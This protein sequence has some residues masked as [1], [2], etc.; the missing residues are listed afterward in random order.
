MAKTFNRTTF[1]VVI[2]TRYSTDLQ[3][4]DSCEDQENRV[5]SHLSKLG[6]PLAHVKVINDHAV[7]GTRNDREG[8][9]E[10]QK[11]IQIGDVAVVAVDE[12]SRLTRGF[13]LRQMV[14]DVVAFQGQF[15]SV[16][17]NMRATPEN[18]AWKLITTFSEMMN[19]QASD[20][21]GFR[22]TRG[23][24]G[25]FERDLS[26]G[27]HPYGFGTSYVDD[28]YLAQLAKH[29]KPPKEIYIDERQSPIVI[30]IFTLYSAGNS[31]NRIAKLL[32]DDHVPFGENPLKCNW[33]HQRIGSIL[34]NEKY[35]GKWIWGKTKTS[36]FSSGKKAQY[37]TDPADWTE[38]DRQHLRIVN[39][40]L[41][42][43]VQRRLDDLQQRLGQKPEQGRRGPIRHHLSGI[44]SHFL[45]GVLQCQCGKRM[46]IGGHHGKQYF[47]CPD[48]LMKNQCDRKTYVPAELAKQK[49]LKFIIGEL[50]Q[51]V[52]WVNQ[53][54]GSM[55]LSIREQQEDVPALI[56]CA[57]KE[58]AG[59]RFKIQ[60]LVSALEEG[61]SSK[62]I[63]EKLAL[64]ESELAAIEAQIREF[65]QSQSAVKK[66]PTV[67][68]FES[69]LED[70]AQLIEQ[71]GEKAILVFQK[72]IPKIVAVE[73]VAPWKERGFA[74]LTFEFDPVKIASGLLNTREGI[75]EEAIS[76]VEAH[77]DLRR[78]ISIDLGQPT[79]FEL[80][81]EEVHR[82]HLAGESLNRLAGRFAV[83]PSQLW[84]NYQK[85]VAYL[86]RSDSCQDSPTENQLSNSETSNLT[87]SAA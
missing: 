9:Q 62:Y 30:R 54:R 69:Q 79:R 52:D 48:G 14:N 72:M 47:R 36:R 8:F 59:L 49:M 20:D 81:M 10:L 40:E 41:W 85:Y 3:S 78:T 61:S 73:M 87:P 86:R 66:L 71:G 68:W 6:I 67:E 7:S 80:I 21:T 65:L 29:K 74:R 18:H 76:K 82:L 51:R 37:P 43:Q 77:G 53:V 16:K 64:R 24:R 57:L 70:I 2:Y 39:D 32:R 17:E 25:R 45:S 42:N 46:Y 50:K 26:A 12:L 63:A 11:L 22:V 5:R 38:R 1:G 83:R 58:K 84:T 23:I 55:E 44:P 60:S 19:N 34:R 13:D 33:T 31:M 35:I 15:I 4:K 27:D 28:D 75:L 56:A